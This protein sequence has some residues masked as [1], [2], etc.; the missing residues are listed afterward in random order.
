M[1]QNIVSCWILTC[2]T[3]QG[4]LFPFDSPPCSTKKRGMTL[5]KRGVSLINPNK[6]QLIFNLLECGWIVFQKVTKYPINFSFSDV[7]LSYSD[8]TVTNVCSANDWNNLRRMRNI[9]SVCRLTTQDNWCSK[10]KN[11]CFALRVN[12]DNSPKTNYFKQERENV[13]QSFILKQ[14]NQSH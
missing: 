11:S 7:V 12:A 1:S 2:W 3:F 8:Q 5:W 13:Q 4:I 6:Y 9:Q 10:E 14:T